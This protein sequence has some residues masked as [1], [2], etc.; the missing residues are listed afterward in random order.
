MISTLG[1]L[2]GIAVGSGDRDIV[3]LAGVVVLCVESIS[4]TTGTFLSSRSRM[5]VIKAKIQYELEEIRTNPEGERK[6][7][8]E[9]YT[10][11]GFPPGGER[12]R[13]QS[14]DE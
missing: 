3:L 14:T 11:R 7:L 9:M 4:M 6:E 13:D 8:E 1:A 12:N 2:T 10:E 5:E